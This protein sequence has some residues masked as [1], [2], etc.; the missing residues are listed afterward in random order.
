VNRFAIK[1]SPRGGI[2]VARRDCQRRGFRRADKIDY[3]K[4]ASAAEVRCR[5]LRGRHLHGPIKPTSLP[6]NASE[7]SIFCNPSVA[8]LFINTLYR[9]REQGK[10]ALHAFV[11]M[12]DHIHAILSPIEITLERAVQLIKGGYSYRLLKELGLKHEAWQ[13]GFSDHRIRDLAD[14]RIHVAYINNNP[15]KRGLCAT[16]KL[17]AYSSANGKFEVD[18]LPQWLKPGV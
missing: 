7:V 5:Y 16:P 8:T 9:Y 14:S 6:A 4:A 2:R 13:R 11:V 12:P 18:T 15:V 3:D 10:Y 1:P 17:F